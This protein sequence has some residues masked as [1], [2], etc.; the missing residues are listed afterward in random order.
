MNQESSP[1]PTHTRFGCGGEWSRRRELCGPRVSWDRW[2]RM[3]GAILG[4]IRSGIRRHGPACVGNANVESPGRSACADTY[5]Y[6][7]DWSGVIRDVEAGSSNLPT[8]TKKSLVT[9]L[10]EQPGPGVRLFRLRWEPSHGL[11]CSERLHATCDRSDRRAMDRLGRP[12]RRCE[13]QT[14]AEVDH[15]T[16]SQGGRRQAARS[17]T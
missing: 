12:G 5:P 8:P 14:A 16:E 7:T 13:R 11:N 3:L 1:D 6:A 10:R 17:A 4:A 9:G 2:R 15:R